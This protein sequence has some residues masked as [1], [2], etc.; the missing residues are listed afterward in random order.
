M[1][2]LLLRRHSDRAAA[3]GDGDRSVLVALQVCNAEVFGVLA[4]GAD[5]SWPVFGYFQIQAAVQAPAEW[6]RHVDCDRYAVDVGSLC[7]CSDGV[8]APGV[9]ALCDVVNG[10]DA[11]VLHPKWAK[12]ELRECGCVFVLLKVKAEKPNHLWTLCGL[13]HEETELNFFNSGL[14]PGDAMLLDCTSGSPERQFRAWLRWVRRHPEWIINY[15]KLEFF[16]YRPPY[17]DDSIRQQFLIHPV[18]PEDPMANTAEQRYFDCFRI[19]PKV[20]CNELSMEQ[21]L[22]L[23]GRALNN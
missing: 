2:L 15:E 13:T 5:E 3:N 19:E 12:D 20:P 23:L 7:L 18:V 17:P 10:Q 11:G 14:G 21:M 8:V 22:G 4:D 16:W 1:K 6:H 9:L